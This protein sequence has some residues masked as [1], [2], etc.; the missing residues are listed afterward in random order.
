MRFRVFLHGTNALI[1]TDGRPQRL[2]FF[3]TRIVEAPNKQ[4]AEL[5]AIRLLKSDDW[6]SKALLNAS[7]D[8]FMLAVEEVEEAA[9]D[10]TATMGYSWYP[11]K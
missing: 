2:G 4:V 1:D 8:P 7:T 9:P 10:E 3:T 6:L 11:M 5:Q